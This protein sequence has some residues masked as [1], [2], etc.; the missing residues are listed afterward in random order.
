MKE[1]LLN[2]FDTA[3][4]DSVRGLRI[5]VE[6]FY[7]LDA[8]QKATQ[9][10]SHIVSV[11]GSARS[12]A[13]ST[14][15]KRAKKLGQKLYESGFGVVTGASQG[16]MKAANEGVHEGIYARLKKNLKSKK[17]E[18]V[19]TPEY[20]AE[21][22]KFSLGLKISLPFEEEF[23]P[24]LGTVATFHYFMVRKFFFATLSSAFIACEGG[25]G[26]RDELFE[27]MTLVQT[28]KT[29]LVPIIYLSPD[30]SHLKADVDFCLKEGYISKDDTYLFDIVTDYKKAVAI[31][32]KF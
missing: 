27:I 22:K 19:N 30:A 7:A 4:T 20:K 14:E 8:Y 3:K 6:Y 15:Y 1:H 17:V 11:F 28:G 10:D 18:I 5:L 2:Y 12:K 13:E 32:K 25:W 24:F 23:N 29:P 21:L 16:I 31:I 9:R 26:T